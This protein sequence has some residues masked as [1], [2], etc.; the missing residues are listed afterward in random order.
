M[1]TVQEND[2]D[3][4]AQ[5]PQR[6]GR[7]FLDP[8]VLLTE[9]G[10][11][12]MA[13]VYL[14]Y[15]A[16]LHDWVAVKVRRPVDRRDAERFQAEARKLSA[17][18]TAGFV[19]VMDV[20]PTRG[21]FYIVMEFVNGEDL[22]QRWRR[23]AKAGRPIGMAEAVA[24]I[25]AATQAVA[26]A[27]R[28]GIVHRD[29]K[30]GNIMISADGALRVADLG[31]AR[32]GG[33]D[34]GMT[35]ERSI[36]GTPGYMAPELYRSATRAS[37]ASDVFALAVT[38]TYLLTG[39]SVLDPVCDSR[40]P[41]YVEQAE[42][43]ARVFPDLTQLVAGLPPELAELLR[44][45]TNPDPAQ[46]IQDADS[47]L[48][49]LRACAQG[50]PAVDLADPAAERFSKAE[51]EALRVA[52]KRALA[53]EAS[54]NPSLP[55]PEPRPTPV[56]TVPE[57]RRWPK[58]A[59][60]GVGLA[61]IA[62]VALV[63]SSQRTP[64]LRLSMEGRE[65]STSRELSVREESEVRLA[66]QC[67]TPGALCRWERLE[68]PEVAVPAGS[69]VT[70]KL[71]ALVGPRTLRLEAVADLGNGREVRRPVVLAIDAKDDPPR[72]GVVEIPDVGDQVHQVQ[73]T[74][75]DDGGV[76]TYDLTCDPPSALAIESL[77]GG[78][79]KLQRGTVP[80]GGA[81]VRVVATVRDSVG[82]L[83]RKEVDVRVAPVLATPVSE[84][85]PLTLAVQKW[86]DIEQGGVKRVTVATAPDDAEVA[87][88]TTNASVVIKRVGRDEFEVQ[89][90]PDTLPGPVTV[91]WSARKV[92]FKEALSE[93]QVNVLPRPTQAVPLPSCGVVVVGP[94]RV[95]QGGEAMVTLDVTPGDAEFQLLPQAGVSLRKDASGTYLVVDA[96]AKPGRRTLRWV[97]RKDGYSTGETESDLEVVTV[98]ASAPAPGAAPAPAAPVAGP[99][100]GPVPALALDTFLLDLAETPARYDGS[101]EALAKFLADNTRQKIVADAGVA[102][103]VLRIRVV[104]ELGRSVLKGSVHD[105]GGRML[106]EERSLDL[107][108]AGTNDSVEEANV[109]PW[110]LLR[111]SVDIKRLAAP[112]RWRGL[113]QLLE[114]GL[115]A[116]AKLR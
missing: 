57:G 61:G 110:K 50:W 64:E 66:V 3:L 99:V 10:R 71:P 74:A 65:V 41:R 96:S 6:G 62:A 68:G 87:G 84:S 80:E 109:V 86:L 53:G 114:D 70:L 98:G 59:G 46:R 29:L 115:A 33:G 92:G 17:L 11:G 82:N 108:P 55:T 95:E 15:H 72:L 13:A 85:S 27:H 25:D 5:A 51:L 111:R 78:R 14:G 20:R 2:D 79:F 90:G 45:A 60:A 30:P 88:V 107:V 69:E 48:K 75:T 52:A 42:A 94:T 22:H 36:M 97:A 67:T 35:L 113:V 23:R 105:A 34:T 93:L 32:G 49:R 8:A 112:E 21:L 4:L 100:P 56:P 43:S 18:R 91:R 76:L 31:I 58:L 102:G 9:L 81:T 77:G 44:D 116:A 26:A 12:G 19:Q 104:R 1:N 83:D 38:L 54:S 103:L 24:L 101:K 37:P 7:P 28:Q 47:F 89:V 63:L 16:N 106:A 40:D 39:K 73:L